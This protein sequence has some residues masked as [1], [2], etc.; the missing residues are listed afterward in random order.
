MKTCALV[1]LTVHVNFLT[2]ATSPR[3]KP[4]G[5]MLDGTRVSA[6]G[7]QHWAAIATKLT[8]IRKGGRC[9]IKAACSSPS[10]HRLA[11]SC[12][13]KTLLGLRTSQIGAI[14]DLQ[15]QTFV[16]R[17]V[18]GR[19]KESTWMQSSTLGQR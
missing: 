16:G 11:I 7:A 10:G 1:G 15:Q 6:D 8:E 2:E 9:Q 19:R 4:L 12:E 13:V 17:I 14:W 18:E 3:L 5:E